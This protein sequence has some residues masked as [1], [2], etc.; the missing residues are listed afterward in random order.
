VGDL[1]GPLARVEVNGEWRQLD[2]VPPDATLGQVLRDQLGQ[3]DVKLPCAEGACGACTVLLDGSAV[4]SCLVYVGR[5]SGRRVT[6]VTGLADDPLG[7]AVIVALVEHGGLQCGYCSPGFV[8]AATAALRGLAG[9]RAVDAR[10]VLA[11]AL[12]GHLCRCTGYRRILDAVVAVATAEG[13]AGADTCEVAP[14]SH[15][16]S[17]D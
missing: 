1:T 4:P 17:G 9:R 6:T 16:P 13:L 7:R 5:A 3:R 8:C 14:A 12:A 10:H 15:S 2:G 11:D